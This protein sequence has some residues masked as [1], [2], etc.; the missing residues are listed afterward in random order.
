MAFPRPQWTLPDDGIID[1][2]AVEIAARGIRPVALTRPER[3]LAAA[4]ILAAGGTPYQ[5]V[6]RL[7]VSCQTAHALAAELTPS[8][9]AEPGSEAA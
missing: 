2:L 1:D 4:L 7:H 5:L 8:P 6:K 3:R 9:A